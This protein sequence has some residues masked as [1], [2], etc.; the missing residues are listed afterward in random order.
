MCTILE[1]VCGLEEDIWVACMYKCVRVLKKKKSEILHWDAVA[2]HSIMSHSL[3]WTSYFHIFQ[4]YMAYFSAF[5]LGLV[6][7]LTL[8]NHRVF[9]QPCFVFPLTIPSITAL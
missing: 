3:L 9:W 6:W 5:M 1:E 4:S 2:I 8:S 7:A